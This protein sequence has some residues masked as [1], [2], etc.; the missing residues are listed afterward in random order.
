MFLCI[1][2]DSLYLL[3]MVIVDLQWPISAYL[4]CRKV[5]ILT[6]QQNELSYVNLHIVWCML[7][8]TVENS[9]C[10]VTSC[11]QY[12]SI[13]YIFVFCFNIFFPVNISMSGNCCKYF[14]IPKEESCYENF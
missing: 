3:G 14:L 4:F 13:S 8:C 12:Y 11:F 6:L 9:Y 10:L 7:H 1:I 2:P 5:S